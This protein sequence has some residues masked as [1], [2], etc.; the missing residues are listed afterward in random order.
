MQDIESCKKNIVN[1]MVITQTQ[2]VK[3]SLSIM[4]NTHASFVQVSIDDIKAWRNAWLEEND[5][6]DGTDCITPFDSYLYTTPA[7]KE[8]PFKLPLSVDG[9]ALVGADCELILEAHAVSDS[10]MA[11]L[12]ELVNFH[13]PTEVEATQGKNKDFPAP[14]DTKECVTGEMT[15][16]TTINCINCAHSWTEESDMRGE[17]VTCSNCGQ[18][19]Q[20]YL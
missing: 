18:E 16:I 12:L 10:E 5:P 1:S 6:Q 9:N 2:L 17:D 15:Q 8:L 4:K 13:T 3:G 11:A 20:V 19:L 14:S 7:P